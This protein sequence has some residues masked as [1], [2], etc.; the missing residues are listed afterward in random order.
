MDQHREDLL[1]KDLDR[2]M[3]NVIGGRP[4]EM[5]NWGSR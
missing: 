4:Q 1:Q 2:F 5:V 3:N